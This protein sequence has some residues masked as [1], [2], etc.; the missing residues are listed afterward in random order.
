M[1]RTWLRELGYDDEEMADLRSE[2][3][4]PEYYET[5]EREDEA[6]TNDEE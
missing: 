4:R 2:Y 6:E 5:N 3:R 1:N